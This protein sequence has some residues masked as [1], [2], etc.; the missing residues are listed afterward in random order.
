MATMVPALQAPHI[1]TLIKTVSAS[2][3]AERPSQANE[4]IAAVPETVIGS[5]PGFKEAAVELLQ[6]LGVARPQPEQIKRVVSIIATEVAVV[7]RPQSKP[8]EYADVG[9]HERLR[10][11]ITALGYLRPSEFHPLHR[12]GRLALVQPYRSLY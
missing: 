8:H 2:L 12:L 10:G 5:T 9:M 11:V 4:T 6:A 3:A 7:G 1:R